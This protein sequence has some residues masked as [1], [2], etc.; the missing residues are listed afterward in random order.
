MDI[1]RKHR[2][3]CV[4]PGVFR[5]MAL[6]GLCLE[7]SFSVLYCRTQANLLLSKKCKVSEGQSHL[8]R[9]HKRCSR[10]YGALQSMRYRQCKYANHCHQH[11][12]T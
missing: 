12:Q 6:L 9:V 4:S 10:R 1:R 8:E 11:S 2:S 3:D 7:L 5:D